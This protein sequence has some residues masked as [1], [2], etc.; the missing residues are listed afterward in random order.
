LMPA[1]ALYD[2]ECMDLETEQDI[3]EE[4]RT[5]YIP[6][7]SEWKQHD[8]FERAFARLLRDL[9][10]IDAPPAPAPPPAQL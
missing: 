4:V 3:A 6:D 8:A 10:A 9:K 2:W 5:Y 7:F 1:E